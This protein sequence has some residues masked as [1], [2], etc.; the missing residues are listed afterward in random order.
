MDQTQLQQKIAEYYAKLPP[1]AQGVFSSMQWLQT[2]EQISIKY[3]L[4]D[5][6]TETLSTETTLVLLGIIHLDE[7]KN[8]LKS[9]L[10]ISN[11]ILQNILTEIDDSILKTIKQELTE[12]FNKNNQ[13]ISE[14]L[15][16]RFSKLSNETK[17]AILESNYQTK[18]YE[19]G[20]KYNL[21]VFQ[22]EILE[23][24]IVDIIIGTTNPDK[25]EES[26]K[27]SLQLPDEKNREIV[28]E[29]NEK[30]LKEIREKFKNT[31]KKNTETEEEAEDY[32]LESREEMLK[33]IENPEP[34]AKIKIPVLSDL[35]ELP[36]GN[37]EKTKI[38]PEKDSPNISP[39]KE[40]LIPNKKDTYSLLTQKLSGSFK[41]PSVETN[42]SLE[43]ITKNSNMNSGMI[44]GS[45]VDPYREIP[46]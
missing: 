45:K 42:H 34:V 43:N 3:G 8:I 10:N 41:I 6:Q 15:D 4:N 32:T 5:A 30:I 21:T 39:E 22:M 33:H 1:E 44:K 16:E 7:Y 14:E 38:K 28:N 12:V 40:N 31:Y 46:E 23:K 24:A 13:P 29:I 17:N 20:Q 37:I 2:L 11:E 36:T 19:I 35:K 9:E 27:Q 18:I 26:L 25:F